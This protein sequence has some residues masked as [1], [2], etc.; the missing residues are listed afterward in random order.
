MSGA[1]ASDALFDVRGLRR[2]YGRGVRR[3]VALDEVS[4]Q[5]GRGQRLGIVGESGSG[6]STLIRLMAGLDT[7]TAGE[8]R[9]DGRVVTGVP[10]RELGFL[11]SRVQIV[12]QDPRASLNP[13]MNVGDIIAEP[14]R[15]RSV[16]RELG[17]VDARARVA[18]LLDAV[19]LPADAPARYPHEFSGGQRQRIAIARALAPGPDVL[20]AD[21]AV[22]A[23]DVSVRAQVLNLLMDLVAELDLTLVFVSHD[24]AVV[25]H[26]CTD[27]V[28]L[29][30]GRLVEAGPA[31]SVFAA[32]QHPYT[33]ALVGAIPRFGGRALESGQ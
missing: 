21:E 9:F 33:R 26:V 30:A 23:L 14:L 3:V 29:Q 19:G 4:L 10:E 24:L 7:P 15:A 28:V 13:R 2:V 12:F 25:R 6:K 11:R 32:P 8:V 20:I 31:A 18:E 16:R 22:S 17:G 1:E 27:A 5:V